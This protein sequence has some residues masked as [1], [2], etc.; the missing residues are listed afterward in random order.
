MDEALSV[1]TELQ[2]AELVAMVEA[3]WRRQGVPPGQLADRLG[4]AGR[5]FLAPPVGFDGSL[6]RWQAEQ[7][8]RMIADPPDPAKA[9]EP[10]DL[11]M[12]VEAPREWG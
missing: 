2:R 7:L 9:E 11:P 5:A 12:I 1:L 6:R 4:D 8:A 10:A 3:G